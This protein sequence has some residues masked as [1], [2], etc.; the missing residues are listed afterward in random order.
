MRVKLGVGGGENIPS[1]EFVGNSLSKEHLEA[2]SCP[3]YVF[4]F[5]RFVNF[6]EITVIFSFDA[7]HRWRINRSRAAYTVFAS[8]SFGSMGLVA[9]I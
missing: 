1:F 5:A 9:Q 2:S 4:R 3:K 7:S 8:F 6:G